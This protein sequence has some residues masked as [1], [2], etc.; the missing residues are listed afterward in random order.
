[1]DAIRTQTH[2]FE[3]NQELPDVRLRD[4]APRVLDLDDDMA[5]ATVRLHRYKHL[6]LI[7]HE[8]KR[9]GRY[10]CRSYAM[11]IEI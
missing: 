3:R 2:L 5:G 7:L 6:A 8:H 9:M 11:Q 4:A 10:E 1:M